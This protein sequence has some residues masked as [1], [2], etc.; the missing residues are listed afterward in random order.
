M[1]RVVPFTGP[2]RVEMAE[3]ARA[4]LLHA[5]AELL[6]A[7]QGADAYVVLNERHAEVL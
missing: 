3:H 1:E 6:P 4:E 2:R 7:R 5:R